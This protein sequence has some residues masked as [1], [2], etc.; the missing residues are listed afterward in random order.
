MEF[1]IGRCG[2]GSWKKQSGGIRDTM[3]GSDSMGKH[4]LQ[5]P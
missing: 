2:T 3:D 4:K 1:H 5:F